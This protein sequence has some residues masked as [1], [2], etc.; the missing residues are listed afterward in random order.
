MWKARRISTSL[1]AAAFCALS[2]A[3]GHAADAA[4]AATDSWRDRMAKVELLVSFQGKG[5]SLTYDAGA[6]KQAYKW[7]PAL[8]EDRFVLAGNSSG[9]TY[10]VYFACFGFSEQ[11]IARAEK[12][13]LRADFSTVRG[14]ENTMKKAVNLIRGH[15][16][17]IDPEA[18]REVIA[19]ALGVAGPAPDIR[20]V[21]RASRAVPRC[22][23]VI[24]AAN[25]EVLANRAKAG[26]VFR[27]QDYKEFDAR[28]FDVSWKPDVFEFYSRRPEQFAKDH[29]DL[30]LGRDRFIGKA[31]TYFVDRTM[32]ELLS[33]IPPEE[34]LGDL[35]LIE[36]PADLAMA[37]YASTAEPT[38]FNPVPET[39]YSKLRTGDDLGTRG[40]SRR[41]KYGGGF[42]MPLVGQ[43]V[44]RMLPAIRVLGTGVSRLP[45]EA[46]RL[47]KAYYLVDAQSAADLSAWWTDLEVSMP[48]P[49]QDQMLVKRKL[50]PK[51]EF[52]RGYDLAEEHFAADHGLP[53]YVVRPNFTWPAREAIVS[54]DQTVDFEEG[55]E[56][57]RALKTMRG[58][59][60]LLRSPAN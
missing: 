39:D 3:L 42:I 58:L 52:S 26:S 43:D 6:I 47:I 28:N 33:R 23:L 37:I 46:R 5:S 21:I 18:L 27:A 55:P 25:A 20:S 49:L 22:G 32:Y 41:R 34:R 36:T 9:S 59:G 1:A 29:P 31:L 54:P 56:R 50:T 2:A 11:T 17:V 24:A 10:A 44:R 19:F 60:P 30:T 53:K 8:K 57:P 35:R 16:P 7:L 4:P 40:N 38:Y 12:H 45:L 14:N 15:E 13:M 48:G 51:E